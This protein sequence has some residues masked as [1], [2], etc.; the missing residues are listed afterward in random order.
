[1]RFPIDPKA[2]ANAMALFILSPHNR[3][4]CGFLSFKRVRFDDL[5]QLSQAL[6]NRFC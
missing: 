1:V 3:L 6:R 4:L 2:M 5:T